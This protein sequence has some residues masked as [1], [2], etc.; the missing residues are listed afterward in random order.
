MLR[1]ID[2]PPA[3]MVPLEMQAAR[4][5]DAEEALQRREAHARRANAR[6]AR[7]FAALQIFFIF[8]WQ[9]VRA[10]G[11]GLAEAF[12]VRGEIEDCGVA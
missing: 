4:R 12:A 7:A 3:L 11:D 5:D 6:Q 10:R 9:T 8:G 1:R 2:I